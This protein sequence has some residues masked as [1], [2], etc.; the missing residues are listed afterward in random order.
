MKELTGVC[1]YH[2]RCKREPTEDNL[3]SYRIAKA[4]ARRVIQHS[5]KIK[6]WETWCIQ[7]EFSNIS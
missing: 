6:I 4:K 5:E 7:V 3:N 2:E 1:I